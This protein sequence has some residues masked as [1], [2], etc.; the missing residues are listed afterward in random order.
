V[1]LSGGEALLHPEIKKI[2]QHAASK[3]KIELSTNGTLIDREWAKFLSDMD[4]RIQISIDGSTRKIHD[5]IRGNG[6]FEKSLRAIEYLQEAGLRKRINFSTT[7]MNQNL[8]DLTGIISLAERLD[9]P[10]VRFLPLRRKGRARKKWEAIGSGL[11]IRDFERFYEHTSRLQKNGGSGVDIS[12]GLSGFLLNMPEEFEGDD[13]WCPVGRQLVVDINGD[14]YPCVLMMENE[15]RLGNA[16]DD[17]LDNI[18]QS[19][20]MIAVCQAL[21]ERRHK[22]KKCSGCNWRNLC[23]SGCM[24]QALDNKGTIWD[25]DDFCDYR[26]SAYKE[27]FNK[28]LA[29]DD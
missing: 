16:F 12:C 17:S 25:T 18:I 10:L 3:V 14:A 4:I 24:G 27:A 23:Q 7:V 28:I 21:S 13:I 29:L 6:A 1:T 8:H 5:S 22:I 19:D 15:F 26:S 20:A 11:T 2:L 9:V